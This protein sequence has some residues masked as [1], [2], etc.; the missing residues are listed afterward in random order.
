MLGTAYRFIVPRV[1]WTIVGQ[2][3]ENMNSSL[4]TE[5]EVLIAVDIEVMVSWNV[6]PCD[7]VGGR[8]YQRFGH[9]STLTMQISPKC[10]YVSTKTHGVIG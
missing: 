4:N 5:S 7:F 9:T 3:Q 1:T 10:R 2:N 6:A 8:A